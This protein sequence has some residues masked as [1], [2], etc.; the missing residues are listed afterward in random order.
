M[1]DMGHM[2]VL[3]IP[4]RYQYLDI[5][6]KG[7]P[8]PLLEEFH[9][10]LVFDFLLLNLRGSVFA[11]VD[12]ID[13]FN[14]LIC[15]P[16]KLPHARCFAAGSDARPPILYR[17]NYVQWSS[18]FMNHIMGYKER[19]LLLK[20]LKEGPYVFRE[21]LDPSNEGRIKMQEEEESDLKELC[22]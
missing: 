7:L 13:G 9:T 12:L 20:S 2:R 4:S 22:T 15:F 14:P 11:L 16:G 6:T 1:V 18:R 17:G 8:S 21:I 19:R 3:H 5:F 10:S